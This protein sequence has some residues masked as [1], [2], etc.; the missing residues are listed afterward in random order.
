MTKELKKLK[1]EVKEL[2]KH[3]DKYL[4]ISKEVF[5]KTL[6]VLFGLALIVFAVG[7]TV[8]VAELPTDLHWRFRISNIMN[9]LVSLCLGFTIIGVSLESKK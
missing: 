8:N 1:Q 2:K 9:L 4:H 5:W 6:G 7:I 3:E